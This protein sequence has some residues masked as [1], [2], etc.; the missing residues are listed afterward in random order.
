MTAV[1][2]GAWYIFGSHEMTGG[3]GKLVSMK[4]ETVKLAYVSLNVWMG[5]TGTDIKSEN[6]CTLSTAFFRNDVPFV[7]H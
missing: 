2:I 3:M 4:R 7:M 1:A 6:R 5:E